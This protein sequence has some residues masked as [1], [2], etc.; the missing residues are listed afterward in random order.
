MLM[1]GVSLMS[2]LMGIMMP[3]RVLSL[4]V[5]QGAMNEQWRE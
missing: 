1:P 2:V 4:L 3:I 5:Q